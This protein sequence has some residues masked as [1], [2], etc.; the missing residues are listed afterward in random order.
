MWG[1]EIMKIAISSRGK[2]LKDQVD[3]RF[4]RCNYFLFI[5]IDDKKIKNVEAI[6][7]NAKAQMGGAGITSAEIIGNRNVEAVITENLGPKAKEVFK[8]LE[9]KTY[10]AKGLVEDVVKSFIEGKLTEIV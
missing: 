1:G 10:Q 4:G 9:I 2:T 6:E 3:P 8:Q 5:E 7:N